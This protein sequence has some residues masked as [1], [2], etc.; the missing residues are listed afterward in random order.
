MFMIQKTYILGSVVEKC[1]F[2]M[3][4]MSGR[5]LDSLLVGRMV[6]HDFLNEHF[7]PSIGELISFNLI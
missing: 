2:H 5:R 4:L 1:N 6:C 3:T 7:N